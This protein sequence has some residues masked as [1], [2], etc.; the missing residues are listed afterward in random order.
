[1][2]GEMFMVCFCMHLF[3]NGDIPEVYLGCLGNTIRYM[4]IETERGDD[5]EDS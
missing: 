1:M 2:K 4:T 5:Y 3:T